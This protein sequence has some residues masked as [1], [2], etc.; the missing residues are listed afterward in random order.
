MFT[1]E[2]WL[3]VLASLVALLWLVR[4]TR[5]KQH[6]DRKSKAKKGHS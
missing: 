1:I 2:T 6:H 5:E 3:T 4:I